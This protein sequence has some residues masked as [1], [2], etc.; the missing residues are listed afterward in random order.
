MANHRFIWI[1]LAICVTATI[2]LQ[3]QLRFPY[4]DSDQF[5]HFALSRLTLEQ[6]LIKELPQVSGLQWN[7]VFPD[8]EFLFHVGSTAAYAIGEES[9]VRL[10]AILLA[11]SLVVALYFLCKT[12]VSAAL[13][14]LLSVAFLTLDPFFVRRIF[15]VRPHVLAVLLFVVLL[16]GLARRLPWLAL[17]GA[18][19]YAL[20]YHAIHLPLLILAIHLFGS[21]ILRGET[22]RELR[23]AA[24]FGIAGLLIGT[25]ANPYFPEHL[26]IGWE[27]LRFA[28]ETQDPAAPVGAELRRVPAL[29]LLKRSPLL[30]ASL[31]LALISSGIVVFKRK[32]S[33]EQAVVL[34][35]LSASVF[36]A[37]TVLNPRGIEYLIPLTA[38]IASMQLARYSPGTRRWLAIGFVIFLGVQSAPFLRSYFSTASPSVHPGRRAAIQAVQALPDEASGTLVFNCTFNT[39]PYLLQYRPDVRFIDLLDPRLYRNVTPENYKLRNLLVHGQ[40]RDPYTVLTKHFKAS[41]VVCMRPGLLRQMNADQRFQRLYPMQPEATAQVQSFRL[42]Q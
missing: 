27:H 5:Y 23:K 6:G 35:G 3:Y 36:A 2:G 17:L 8:K 31:I 24:L 12:Y 42:I 7:R 26:L 1:A 20:A 18:L 22:D 9:A 33:S 14:A 4:P 34:W 13:A 32:G 40:L 10:Y 15:L 28:F 21:Y 29:T 39:G 25:L 11:V 30:S 38:L 37:A 41:Y 19:L 16:L